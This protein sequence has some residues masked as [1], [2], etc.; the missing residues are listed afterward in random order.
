M[1]FNQM[2]SRVNN[3]P[4][5]WFM[6]VIALI[7]FFI[8]LFWVFKGIFVLLS[9]VAPVLL[10][11]TAIINYRVITDYLGMLWSVFK[12]NWLLGILGGVL[13][14]VGFPLVSGFL[15]VKALFLNKVKAIKEEQEVRQKG[16]FIEYEDLS[17]EDPA[18]KLILKEPEIRKRGTEEN[19]YDEV[20]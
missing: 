7:A 20:F 18:E 9:Y 15:F 11:I 19:P 14:V 16:E 1:F 17:E 10:L 8:V 2:Q 4:L 13:T 6:G 5:Q 3:N 12:K